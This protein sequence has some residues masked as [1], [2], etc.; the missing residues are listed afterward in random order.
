[1]VLVGCKD[2]S[3]VKPMNVLEIVSAMRKCRDLG[4]GAI[5]TSGVMEGIVLEI[6]CVEDSK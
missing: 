4:M 2:Q 5:V 1:M 3:I 6:T